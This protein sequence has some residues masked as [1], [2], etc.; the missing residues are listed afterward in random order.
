MTLF[1]RASNVDLLW[2]LRSKKWG[3]PE[4]ELVEEGNTFLIDC[5]NTT[6]A[7]VPPYLV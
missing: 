5:C 4:I 3:M 7:F 1:A 2:A 6:C